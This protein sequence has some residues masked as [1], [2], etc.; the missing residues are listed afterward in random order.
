MILKDACMKMLRELS[1]HKNTDKEDLMLGY[2]NDRL[3]ASFETY[4][5]ELELGLDYL[6]RKN[7]LNVVRKL[8]RMS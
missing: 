7:E 4:R 8:N 1:E 5:K 2:V 6:K 3:N